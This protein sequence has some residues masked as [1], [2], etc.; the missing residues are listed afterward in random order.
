MSYNAINAYDIDSHISEIYDSVE[1]Y[2]DDIELIRQLLAG[3]RP[4]S[5]LEPFC[6]T[7]RILIPLAQH[8][9]ELVGMDSSRGMLARAR[10][11]TDEQDHDVRNRIRLI[12]ADVVRRRWP[13]GFDAIILGGNCFYE[14]PTAEEQERCIA[15]S[16]ASL[17]PGGYV[18]LD[19]N[20]MEGELDESWR[21]IRRSR[22][23]FPSG[24]CEDGTRVES[25]IETIWYDAAKRLVRFRRRTDVSYTD[26]S[27]K[28]TSYVQQKH[29]VSAAE[30]RE[31]LEKYEFVV[32][33]VYGDR[34]GSPY[35][36]QSDRA[37][38]WARKAG[39]G[40]R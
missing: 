9:H 2:E 8:G 32:E 16:A 3:E 31:W 25:R 30:V 18:Y 22:A 26:G 1:R 19:N 7:G 13:G 4:L 37:I 12:E 27:F 10:M 33:A 17:K 6:G 14:L 40:A 38:F 20:H 34:S 11:K 23:S 29:P 28:V 35:T 15:Y 5:I 39:G 21:S 36:E 24:V